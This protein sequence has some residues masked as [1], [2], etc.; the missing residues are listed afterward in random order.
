MSV[1]LQ[2]LMEEDE[3]ER[4]REAASRRKVTV[5]EWVRQAIR[6]AE[7]SEPETTAGTKL[8]IIRKAAAHSFPTADIDTMLREIERGY[9]E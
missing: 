6:K 4:L 5:S 2:L 8:Q 7:E 1:R 3:M 9:L